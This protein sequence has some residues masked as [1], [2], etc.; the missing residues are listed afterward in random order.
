MLF[1]QYPPPVPPWTGGWCMGDPTGM[2]WIPC[3]TPPMPT[4]TPLPYPLPFEASVVSLLNFDARLLEPALVPLL[5]LG[6]ILVFLWVY[7]RA[8]F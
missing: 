6:I 4:P 8:I 3:P 5:L 2:S 1:I 7:K